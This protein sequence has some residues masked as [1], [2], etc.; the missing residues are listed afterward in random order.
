MR[1]FQGLSDATLR[2]KIAAHHFWTFGLHNLRIRCRPACDFQERGG[3]E[4]KSFGEDEALC[5]RQAIKP[6]DEIDRQL[7]TPAV[8]DFP[9]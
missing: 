7:G 9:T 2:R 6:E 8:A 3:I 4:A 5:Q 1:V